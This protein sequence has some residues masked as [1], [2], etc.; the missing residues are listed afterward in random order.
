MAEKLKIIPLG[1]LHE[2]GKNVTVYEFGGDIIV[3][4]C[5]MAFP[6]EDMLGIDLV[7]PDLSYL[8][9]HRSRIKGVVITHG[10]EDHIG[11]IPY[12]LREFSPPIYA[13]PLARGL[14]EGKLEEAG[15]LKSAKLHTIQAGSVLTLGKFMVEAINVNHSTPGAVAFAI[16]TPIGTVIHTGDFKIDTTPVGGEMIDLGRFGELGKQGVLALLSDSTNVERPGYTMSEST[17]GETFNNMFKGCSQ[18]LIVTTF[19]SNVHRIQQIIEAAIRVGRKVAISGRSMENILGIAVNL[20]YLNIPKGTLVDINQIKGIANNKL[21]IIT[22]GSQGETMSALYRMAMGAHRQVEITSN[23]KIIISASPIPGNEKTIS[24]LINELLKKGA[25][26]VYE[27][28][29]ALHVSGHACQ[30]ELKIVMGLC[31]P[32]YFMPVHGEYKHLK[33]HAGLALNMGI[34]KKNIF[35]SENGRILEL[36]KNG[37][38]LAGSVQ[39]GQILIDGSRQDDV[40]SVVLRDRKLLSEDGIITVAFTI[41]ADEGLLLSKPS[42]T[43]RGFVYAKDNENIIAALEETA[44]AAF[45]GCKNKSDIASI[46]SSVKAKLSDQIYKSSKRRP[47]I[48]PIIMEI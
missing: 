22:T 11:A 8:K 3:V 16:F 14:I 39:V 7:M 19:A 47:M 32:Q 27:R 26:V 31:K 38:K 37:G 1:G 30:E 10:H 35:L 24:R 40:G 42:I 20:G 12:M 48:L 18:R 13:T 28:L 41:S 9:K 46:K 25:D 23:D 6:S 21:V 4:D 34:P 29:N 36:T 2:V 15:L 5:G 33:T 45:E 44:L 43:T 17:V